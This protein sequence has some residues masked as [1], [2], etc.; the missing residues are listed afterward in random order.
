[1]VKVLW[2]GDNGGAVGVMVMVVMKSD[3]GNLVKGDAAI[4]C[5]VLV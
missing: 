1:M 5:M 2:D 3:N 4:G